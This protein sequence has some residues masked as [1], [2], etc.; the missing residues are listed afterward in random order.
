MVEWYQQYDIDPLA[1]R[2]RLMATASPD[3]AQ[4]ELKS[5]AN[6]LYQ[7]ICRYFGKTVDDPKRESMMTMVMG[8]LQ[9]PAHVDKKERKW[10]ADKVVTGMAEWSLQ[11]DVTP[12]AMKSQL[13]KLASPTEADLAL[14]SHASSLDS[15]AYHYFGKDRI[16]LNQ[17]VDSRIAALDV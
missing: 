12:G 16:R 3:Q 10:T 15:A 5:H 14:K 9:K 8:K 7:A 2:N 1:M 6:S 4:R 11:F 13:S 17:L